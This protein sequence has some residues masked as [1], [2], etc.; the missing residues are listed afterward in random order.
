MKL[1]DIVVARE[2]EGEENPS[3]GTRIPIGVPIA[4]GSIAASP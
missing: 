2:P 4:C 1:A 3:I